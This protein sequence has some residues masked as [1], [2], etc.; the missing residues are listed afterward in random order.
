MYKIKVIGISGQP[1]TEELTR[2]IGDCRALVASRRH[3][4][5]LPDF[6]G[7]VVP[8]APVDDMLD[9]IEEILPSG[10]VVV[11]A[12]G[13]PLFFGIGRT[14]LK[15]FSPEQLLFSP[16]LSA[17][18]L[19]CARFKV[20]WDDLLF[21]TFHGREITNTILANILRR[22][23]TLLFTDPHNSPDR[24][25][26]HLLE[27]LVSVEDTTRLADM[28]VQVAENI[29]LEKERLVKGSLEQITSQNFAPLNMMLISQGDREENA[30]VFGL[31]EKEIHH[32]RGLITKDE[33]RAAIIHQLRLPCSGVFWDVG[34]GSGSI[35]LEAGGICPELDIYTIEKKEEGQENIRKNIRQNGRYNISLVCGEAPHVLTDLPDPDRIFIGG[36]GGQLEAIISQAASRLCKG[37]ILV[38]SA[39]LEQTAR[40]APLLCTRAGLRV[41]QRKITVERALDPAGNNWQ[42]LN[43]ITI[44][45]ANK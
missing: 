31:Q 6:S 7:A 25:A 26:S 20:P 21:L 14:L 4:L 10:D 38:L 23:H 34:G 35:S 41:E 17:A 9:Q 44:I 5:L 43:S 19:A 32:S 37:G 33:I 22:Q 11:L 45:T 36:S 8:I 27:K 18:Q 1:S 39:V 13:D 24:I 3:R 16:A 15:R 28:R 12:S 42:Q 2:Q 29:G 30:P 40:E